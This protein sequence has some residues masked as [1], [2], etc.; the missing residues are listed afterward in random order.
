MNAKIEK[1]ISKAHKLMHEKGLSGKGWTLELNN[2]KSRAGVCK[3]RTKTIEL[4]EFYLVNQTEESSWNT[5]THE[6]AHAMVGAGHGHD[7]VWKEAHKS[8]GGDGKRTFVPTD[9]AREESLRVAKWTGVCP[10]NPEHVVGRFRLTKSS[11]KSSC[12]VCS[13]RYNPDLMFRWTKNY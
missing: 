9:M 6:I 7:I 2:N 12:G 8:L 3:Y 13:D 1:I 5:V 11:K 4:S 10:A